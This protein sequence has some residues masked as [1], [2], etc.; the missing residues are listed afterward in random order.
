MNFLGKA[1]TVIILVMSIVFMAFSIMVF[2]THRNWKDKA[3]TLEASLQTQ[4]AK[5]EA[6]EKEKNRTLEALAREQAAR[7]THVAVLATTAEMAKTDLAEVT[8]QNGQLRQSLERTAAAH[9]DTVKDYNRLTAEVKEVRDEL[10]R[11]RLDRDTQYTSAVK[12]T[13]DVNALRTQYDVLALRHEQLSRDAARW[14]TVMDREGLDPNADIA[15]IPPK[16]NGEVLVSAKNLIEIS[17]GSDDGLKAGHH[18]EVYRGNTY[19]GRAK[20]KQTA[21]DRAVAEVLVEFRRGIIR[22]GDRVKTKLS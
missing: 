17:I 1:F 21:P 8:D 2:A 7:K 19:L 20:I 3:T 9:D 4:V 16:I 15:G 13:D 10:T 12:A 22:K 6:L 5:N 18:V 14:L 11:A